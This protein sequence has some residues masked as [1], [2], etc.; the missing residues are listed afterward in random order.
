MGSKKCW[1]AEE[2]EYLEDKYG[3]TS[4]KGIAKSL[5]RSISSIKNKKVRMGL[6]SFLEAGEY[7]SFNQLLKALNINGGIQYTNT[8]WI[9]NRN[10]PI[11]YKTVVDNKF[12]VVYLKD[13]WIWA[14]KNRSRIDWFKVETNILGLEPD[15]VT[16]QRKLDYLKN[17]KVKVT[18]WTAE[19]D[20]NLKYLLKQFKYG[21]RELSK[22]LHRTDGAIQRRVCDLGLNERPVKANNHIKWTEEELALLNEMLEKRYSYEL[23]SE[24]IGR[25]GKA[26]RGKIYNIYRT[27]NLDKVAAYK[28]GGQ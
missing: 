3:I 26:I 7:V 1:S 5:G 12:R 11:K 20:E 25:S 24:N 6:G 17:T 2:L 15:W 22:M 18:P 28:K 23:M 4:I 27:E 8:S 16:E 10:F 9:Q 21:Y 13:F 14:E 19:E